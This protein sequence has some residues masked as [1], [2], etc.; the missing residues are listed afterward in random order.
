MGCECYPYLWLL[1]VEAYCCVGTDELSLVDLKYGS[2]SYFA[3]MILDLAEWKPHLLFKTEE[4][5]CGGDRDIRRGNMACNM[6]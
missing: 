6:T 3:D 4:R 5:L 1:L 2:N